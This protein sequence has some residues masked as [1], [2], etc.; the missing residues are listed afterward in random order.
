MRELT[1]H[2]SKDEDGPLAV[3]DFLV[4]EAA[5]IR[6]RSL[7]LALLFEADDAARDPVVAVRDLGAAGTLFRSPPLPG[8]LFLRLREVWERRRAEGFRV[9]LVAAGAEPEE[10]GVAVFALDFAGH[11]ARGR[12]LEAAGDLAGALEAYRASSS[13]TRDEEVRRVQGALEGRTVPPPPEEPGEAGLGDEV[14]V[15]EVLR[16]IAADGKVDKQELRVLQALSAV[17]RID[18]KRLRDMIT[19]VK[20]EPRPPDG[21]AMVPA[22]VLRSLIRRAARQGRIG[23][24]SSRTLNRAA[25]A[26]GL[27]VE[28]I[29]AIVKA[30]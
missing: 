10:I 3:L 24:E 21:K 6:D 22:E 28:E 30:S 1:I 17:F 13:P 16:A 18:P 27:T 25:Q 20:S 9:H 4:D 2:F 19:T 7:E 26:L 14:V 29:R 8:T 5:G 11:L 23:P 15:L 12:A